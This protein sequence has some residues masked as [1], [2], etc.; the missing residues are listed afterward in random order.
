[1]IAACVQHSC[2]RLSASADADVMKGKYDA[3]KVF[4]KASPVELT[5]GV[6]ETMLNTLCQIN[7]VV[8]RR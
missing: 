6:P 2:E 8:A 1:M 5:C 7:Q 4:A 3:I